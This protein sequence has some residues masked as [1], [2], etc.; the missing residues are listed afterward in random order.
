M[1]TVDKQYEERDKVLAF[2]KSIGL[3]TRLADIDVTPDDLPAS[4]EKA[5]QGIDV[6][7]YPYEVT[8]QMLIDG[9]KELEEL[10]K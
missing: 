8:Q 3:P 6:R 10:Q 5:L 4:T 9:V 1:L 2:N 7:V